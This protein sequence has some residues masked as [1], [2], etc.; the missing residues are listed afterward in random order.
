MNGRAGP[1]LIS[2]IKLWRPRS[3]LL[4]F[5]PD[6][7]SLLILL[8]SGSR[9]CWAAIAFQS[10]PMSVMALTTQVRSSLAAC[11][12]AAALEFDDEG[13]EDADDEGFWLL[14]QG[15]IVDAPER[16]GDV[17]SAC[18][19]ALTSVNSSFGRERASATTLALPSRYLMSVVNSEIQAN[20][21][22]CLIV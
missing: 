13:V 16:S 2:T 5:R 14:R 7:A 15:E 10:M 12:R 21:Y 6:L 11:A 1:L 17:V 8:K 4:K 20:W 22:V 9:G 19:V 3:T 18:S